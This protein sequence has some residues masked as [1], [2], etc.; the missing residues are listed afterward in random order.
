M[1]SSHMP[2]FPPDLYENTPETVG[3]AYVAPT[4]PKQTKS[5]HEAATTWWPCHIAGEAWSKA[6]L[7]MNLSLSLCDPTDMGCVRLPTPSHAFGCPKSFPI[8]SIWSWHT[9]LRDIREMKPHNHYAKVTCLWGSNL[10][11]TNPTPIRPWKRGVVPHSNA[12]SIIAPSV[13]AFGLPLKW[14]CT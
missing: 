5:P 7:L 6:P 11:W 1:N 13:V 9:W 14:W 3:C 2:S 4:F 8:A 10:G 12:H